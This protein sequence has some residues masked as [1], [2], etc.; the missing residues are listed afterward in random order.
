MFFSWPIRWPQIFGAKIRN[1]Y[2]FLLKCNMAT[3]WTQNLYFSNT[4]TPIPKISM[5]TIK[6][7]EIIQSLQKNVFIMILFCIILALSMSY[8]L[9]RRFAEEKVEE[10]RNI[11]GKFGDR[12]KN[13]NKKTVYVHS[14]LTFAYKYWSKMGQNNF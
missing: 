14:M 13:S 11:S 9:E 2:I 6:Y 3:T 12:A 4:V 10:L 7:V 8:L 1:E 5:K